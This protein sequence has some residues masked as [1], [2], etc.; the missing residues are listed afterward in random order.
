VFAV[1]LK[2]AF[3]SDLTPITPTLKADAI[4]VFQPPRCM[5]TKQIEWL[6]EHL[7]GLVEKKMAKKV[8]DSTSAT[9]IEQKSPGVDGSSAQGNG[10][11][12]QST[13]TK[14]ST[15]RHHLMR[16]N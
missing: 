1:G 4:P 9:F 5:S 3:F 7:E 10:L 11:S 2:Q 16:M 12:P 15:P 14:Y 13:T 6:K 8:S